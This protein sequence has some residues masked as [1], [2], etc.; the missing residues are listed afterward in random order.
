MENLLKNK[1][2]F[3]IN[4]IFLVLILVF[5]ILLMVV[6]NPYVF[7]ILASVMFVLCGITNLAYIIKRRVVERHKLYKYLMVVGLIFAFLGDVFLIE[8]ATFIPGAI[9]FAVG[10]IFFFV[11][12]CLFYKI[13]W[14]DVLISLAIFAV[15]MLIILVPPIFDFRGMLPVVIVYALII[16]IML[17]KAVSNVF[18]RDYRAENIWIMLGS[19]LFFLSDAMLLFS[20]F[21]DISGV[22]HTL[23]LV[24]YYPAEFLLASSIVYANVKK[25]EE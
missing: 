14:R 24:L 17:G 4:L 13:N 10:H 23:C 8:D 15:A 25:T 18:N 9:L 1:P 20:M 11:S 5:D 22:F 3:I 16:S 19:L 21:T 12:Y 2:I 7:K 6:G